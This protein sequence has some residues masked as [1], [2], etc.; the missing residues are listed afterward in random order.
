MIADANPFSADDAF[1]KASF[2]YRSVFPDPFRGRRTC[3]VHRLQMLLQRAGGGDAIS[4]LFLSPFLTSPDG[5]LNDDAVLNLIALR[6]PNLRH[7]SL[8]GSYNGSQGAMLEVI[9]RCGK[10]EII[11]FSDS[12]YFRPAILQEV[13]R[14]CPN[15]K[16]IR[17]NGG[18]YHHF[19]S[20]LVHLLNLSLINL[21]GSTVWDAD[22][23]NI[24]CLK[25]VQYLD[26]TRCQNLV[27]Y[28]DLIKTACGRIPHICY[29]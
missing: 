16:G 23:L 1:V 10:L 14:C 12:P 22:L 5:P 25:K 28:M 4:S 20:H 13:G 29:D 2:P 8:H 11:D 19:S 6:C 26:I 18:V 9:G 27:K 17:R 24:L 15:I 21:S 7:L 3:G